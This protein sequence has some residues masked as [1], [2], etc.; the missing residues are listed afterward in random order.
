MG[1]FLWDSPKLKKNVHKKVYAVITQACSVC[2]SMHC[3]EIV[4]VKQVTIYP[5]L[6]VIFVTPCVLST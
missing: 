4:N 5:S 6:T 2:I 3:E 1:L